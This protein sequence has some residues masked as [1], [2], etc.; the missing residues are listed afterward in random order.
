MLN[1]IKRWLFP[2]LPSGPI[3]LIQAPYSKFRSPHVTPLRIIPNTINTVNMIK[4]QK[5][6][7][8]TSNDP[9]MN[10]FN[11]FQSP[12]FIKEASVTGYHSNNFGPIVFADNKLNEKRALDTRVTVG[13]PPIDLPFVNSAC[14]DWW[15]NRRQLFPGMKEIE[16]TEIIG[17]LLKDQTDPITGKRYFAKKQYGDL[18][19]EHSAYLI[20]SNARP[21]VKNKLYNTFKLLYAEGIDED[22]YI[23]HAQMMQWTLR[24]SFLKME[25]LLY[26]TLCGVKEKAPRFISG[27]EAQFICLVGPWM[28]ACQDRLKRSWTI[29]HFVTFT[30]GKTNE[31]IGKEAGNHLEKSV[32]EDDISVFDSSVCRE[33][34][35]FE[36][37]LFDSWGAPRAVSMLIKNNVDTRGR[38]KWGYRYKVKGT[39]KSGDPYTSL[40]N[41]ILN[42][43]MHYYIYKVHYGLT[44]S[45]AMKGLKMFVAG[46]DNLGFCSSPNVPWVAY[47]LRFGFDSEAM[48]RQS[49]FEAEFCSCR[50]Y[51]TD[52][53]LV[54]GP[55]PGKVLAKFG[56]YVQPPVHVPIKQL[57]RGSALGLYKQCYFIPPIKIF[58]DKVLDYTKGEKA[59]FVKQGDWQTKTKLFHEAVPQ[60]YQV[61]EKTYGYKTHY[62]DYLIKN[63]PSSPAHIDI[64]FLTT[65]M[66]IDTSGPHMWFN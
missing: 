18:K 35:L 58:L 1:S 31:D 38:T 30:S 15:K 40:G 6:G 12:E 59:Y 62:D 48:Y 26:R 41:S 64:P 34:L 20:R 32:F 52:S 39:R 51:P 42:G 22:S 25:N 16:T 2:T 24:S 57:L 37:K 66:D 65:M 8:L 36:H 7:A 61:L 23:T 11:K 3:S 19:P 4:P 54:L 29:E 28:M 56:Y 53:G 21:M 43:L 49:I 46:D 9:F 60:T 27:A 47:M 63:L 33:L 45:Q 44:T 13:T 17:T 14:K 10:K 50:I 55:K 5:R